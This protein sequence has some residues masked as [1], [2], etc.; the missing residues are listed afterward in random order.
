MG[1]RDAVEL[2]Q[3][4]FCLVPKVLNTVY[5]VLFVC[6]MCAVINAEM[7]KFA[8]IQH[9]VA[10]VVIG[11]NNA[12]GFN[13]LTNNRQ[14]SDSLCIRNGDGINLTVSL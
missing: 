1:F 6:K 8:D 11:I 2:T 9:I 13:L 4:A 7:V 14:Q 3:M 5:M 10:F 12:I